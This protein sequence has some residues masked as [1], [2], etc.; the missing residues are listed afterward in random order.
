MATTTTDT[1]QQTPASTA[2]NAPSSTPDPNQ[3]VSRAEFDKL[4][5]IANDLRASDEKHRKGKAEAKRAADERAKENHEYKALS[6]SQA[7]ELEELRAWKQQ[8]APIVESHKTDTDARKTNLEA[9]IQG[10]SDDQKALVMS[11]ATLTAQENLAAHFLQATP[12]TSVKP[13]TPTTPTTQN[14]EDVV[15]PND[16]SA[17]DE[18]FKTNPTKYREVMDGAKAGG[19][20]SSA[21]D[22]IFGP[23]GT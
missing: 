3:W 23:Q 11:G 8:H 13:D 4:Q 16:A 17:L 7:Q 20:G 22:D 2:N 12:T 15:D 6:E 10:L 21:L 18:L 9:K 19:H 14:S 5:S 1:N